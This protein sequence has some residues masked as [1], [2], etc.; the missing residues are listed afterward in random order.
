M[1]I[2]LDE[3]DFVRVA[4]G[5]APITT[6]FKFTSAGELLPGVNN[7]GS[8]GKEGQKWS[9]VR[10]TTITSGDLTFENGVKATEEGRGLAFIND[11]GEKIAVLD[12]KGNLRIK[13]DV[14]KDPTL[15]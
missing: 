15:G 10:A 7:T 11:A 12:H 9:L 8:I 6:P 3:V 13:G 1:R 14:I 4:P 2:D 5:G